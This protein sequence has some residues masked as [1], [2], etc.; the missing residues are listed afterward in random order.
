MIEI[1]KKLAEVQEMLRANPDNGIAGIYLNRG[2]NGPTI[3]LLMSSSKFDK[4]IAPEFDYDTMFRRSFDFPISKAATICG[5]M[6]EAL[7]SEDEVKK[8]ADAL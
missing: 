5:I 4:T 8:D 7:Y 6:V 3:S 2:K 1:C